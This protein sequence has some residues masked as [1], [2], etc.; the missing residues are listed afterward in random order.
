MRISPGRPFSFFWP[1]TPPLPKTMADASAPA[2][3]EGENNAQDVAQAVT[4]AREDIAQDVA[5][6]IAPAAV[7]DVHAEAAAPQ[8]D[9]IPADLEAMIDQVFPADQR[10][11]ARNLVD[12]VAKLAQ[13][14]RA[15]SQQ[16]V[17][18]LQE[19]L[20]R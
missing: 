15:A 2:T 18:A 16:K 5:Q 20:A 12:A 7:P 10:A 14:E 13:Q 19:Q 8:P 6:D 17:A 3:A 11:N 4:A 9:A 1:G